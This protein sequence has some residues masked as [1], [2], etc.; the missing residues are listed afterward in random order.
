MS[1]TAAD[2]DIARALADRGIGPH[3]LSDEQR[4]Q[5]DEIGCLVIPG[6]IPA[7]QARAMARRLDEIFRAEGERAGKDFQTEAGTERVG[8][9]VTKDPIFDRGF[10]EPFVLAAVSHMIGG[11]FG[12]SSLTSRA[13]LPNAGR[14]NFHADGGPLVVGG[15]AIW[16][17]DEFTV[18][19]GAT[20]IVP[21]SHLTKRTP[22]VEGDE[23]WT[24]DR[25]HPLQ[26]HVTGPIGSLALMRPAL[27][28]AG[29]LN[30]T[31]QPRRLLSAYFSPRGQ[32]QSGFRGLVPAMRERFDQSAL[33]ILDH[34]A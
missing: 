5:L 34:V 3:L 30:T 17:L 12:L 31:D 2:Y 18:A 4:R 16:M 13:A 22:F 7:D 29:S 33:Y 11:E 9:L 15:H 23:A 1:T 20:R 19:N 21:G 8:A 32:Y 25:D 10:L 14:Q 28:H 6:L 27:W 24:A 26:Q